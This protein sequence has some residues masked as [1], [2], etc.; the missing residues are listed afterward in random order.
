MALFKS[1]IAIGIYVCGLLFMLLM[2]YFFK[3]SNKLK[4]EAS[5]NSEAGDEIEEVL[6]DEE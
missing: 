2:L 6:S 4:E 1:P 5:Q 3:S